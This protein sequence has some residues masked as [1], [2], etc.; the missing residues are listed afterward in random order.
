MTTPPAQIRVHHV[1]LDRAWTDD[2]D[3]DHEVVKYPRLQARQHVH[4]RSAF[5]LE[6]ADRF[7]PAKHVI[8]RL[9]ILRNRRQFI[10]FAFMMLDQ[11]ETFSDAGQ[12]PQ[13]QHIDLHHVQR[14]DI[15]LVPLNEGA[16]VH[17]GV[18]DRHVSIEPV[19]RQY[20]TADMLGQVARKLEQL[21]SQFDGKLDHRILRIEPRLL[22]LRFV[23]ILAPASPYR[24]RQRRRHIFGQ[25]QRLSDIAN[26]AARPVMNDGG[27]NCGAMPAIPAVDILHHLFTSRMLEIDVDVR[28]LQTFPGD[29]AL[30]QQ[31]DLGRIDG[32]N[33]EHIANG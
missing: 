22:D 23:E 27:D 28:R 11:V 14:I 7:T 16:V 8:D 10:A 13:C 3:L 33:I 24:I 15:V 2:G 21:G 19:L 18:A 26:C 30:E 6:D 5:D 32:S 12:H 17:R 25:P 31:I 29:K 4:L 9:L 20:I 1:A